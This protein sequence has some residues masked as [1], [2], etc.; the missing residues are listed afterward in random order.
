M[1]CTSWPSL[2]SPCFLTS[3]VCQAIIDSCIRFCHVIYVN[4]TK[5]IKERVTLNFVQVESKINPANAEV[6]L[7]KACHLIRAELLF[8]SFL[9]VEFV[10]II[11]VTAMLMTDVGYQMCCWQ[12]WDVGDRFRM[13]VTDFIH[14]ENYKHNEKSRQHND[15]ATNISNRSPS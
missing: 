8:K 6:L 1:Q 15:S 3:I 7:K 11:L 9:N 13:L 14:C 4:R 10:G 5:S 2:F 12:V